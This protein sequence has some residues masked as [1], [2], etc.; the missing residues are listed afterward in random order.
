MTETT[1]HNGGGPH[2]SPAADIVP[3]SSSESGE[4][5]II[6]D[7]TFSDGDDCVALETTAPTDWTS[8]SARPVPSSP[9]PPPSGGP[10]HPPDPA[11]S[12]GST[13]FGLEEVVA[14]DESTVLVTTAPQFCLLLWGA[15]QVRVL[16]GTVC[17]HGAILTP[18]RS[19]YLSVFALRVKALP[20][21]RPAEGT[22]ADA[23]ECTMDGLP[24]EAAAALRGTAGCALLL[25]RLPS[26][27]LS[28][29]ADQFGDT[30]TP[31]ASDTDDLV[32]SHTGCWLLRDA[33]ELRQLQLS[34]HVSSAQWE[35]RLRQLA[36]SSASG[37]QWTGW[38]GSGLCGLW[39]GE[40]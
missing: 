27:L 16:R 40:R 23:S 19:D 9:P 15:Y 29:L 35:Q 37:G 34:P 17:I 28:L 3:S 36:A 8:S 4:D 18:A 11:E 31:R 32:L 2:A 22:S 6:D 25:R 39:S 30:F 26:R 5:I 33:A 1:D 24:K 21:L 14:V 10:P 7:C 13:P 20:P 12:A 38:Q